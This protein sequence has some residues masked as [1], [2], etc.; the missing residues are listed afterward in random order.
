MAFVTNYEH[1]FLKMGKVKSKKLMSH[2][3]DKI[4]LFG[5]DYKNI[6]R[7]KL[8]NKLKE[9]KTPYERVFGESFI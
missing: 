3:M 2:I 8:I 5:I 1:L 4:V 9:M 7:I 6:E